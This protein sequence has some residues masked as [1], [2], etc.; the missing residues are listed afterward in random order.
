MIEIAQNVAHFV[1]G[2]GKSRGRQ[3][4]ERYASFDY[5]FNYFQS[6][7]ERRIVRKLASARYMEL[8]CLQLGFYLASW[9]MLR[10]S[11]FLLE[12][13]APFYR[14][15]IWASRH[16]INEYGPSTPTNIMMKT[17]PCCWRVEK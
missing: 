9:G 17:L 16:L 10:G 2:R 13:S 11:S 7:Q 1:E 5:C 6:F 8:S 12:K 3:P 15:L 14:R 4:S